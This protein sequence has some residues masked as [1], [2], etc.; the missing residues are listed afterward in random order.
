[1]RSN[2]AIFSSVAALML[3]VQLPAEVIDFESFNL[4]GAVFL[5]TPEILSF[6]NVGGSGVNV[7]INGGADLRI[8]DLVQFGSYAFPGPQALI[9]MN[10]GTFTNPAGT[11]IFFSTLVSNFSLIAGDFGSDS[12][13]P[14]RIEAFNAGGASLGVATA[15]WPA[16]ANPPFALLSLNLSGISRVHYSSGGS[17]T[18]STFVDNITFTPGAA[19]VP[20]PRFSAL[21]ALGAMTL[22]LLHRKSVRRTSK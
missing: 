19:A 1:M 4:A 12:D 14:L 20:E 8:Y 18:G 7:T 2:C 13:T 6:M 9:D 21:I 11:D 22:M 10:W 3:A 15:L 5:D 17:F 16:T